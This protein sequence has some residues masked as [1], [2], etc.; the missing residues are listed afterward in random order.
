MHGCDSH[1]FCSK[2]NPGKLWPAHQLVKLYN[3]GAAHKRGSFALC[4]QLLEHSFQ[5]L[6][7][8]GLIAQ[9]WNSCADSSNS[10]SKLMNTPKPT[11]AFSERSLRALPLQASQ[12]PRTCSCSGLPGSFFPSSAPGPGATSHSSPKKLQSDLAVVGV[13]DM[14]LKKRYQFNKT[15][16]RNKR[17]NTRNECQ[18]KTMT[19][20]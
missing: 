14:L 11:R 7:H 3:H 20:G 13:V 12:L 19:R 2:A 9:S 15:S 6:I 16:V 10:A 8:G 17:R 5:L 4:F 18:A 1:S